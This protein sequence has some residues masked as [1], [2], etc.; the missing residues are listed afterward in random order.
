MNGAERGI[1]GAQ[2]ARQIGTIQFA[3]QLFFRHQFAFGLDGEIRGRP[4]FAHGIL[5][6]LKGPG[7]IGIQNL[8]R[9]FQINYEPSG[10]I[11]FEDE[12]N[13]FSAAMKIPLPR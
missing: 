9:R 12:K 11:K 4:V 7:G 5:E 2:D 8:K 10:Q 13:I 6:P 1:N 3:D